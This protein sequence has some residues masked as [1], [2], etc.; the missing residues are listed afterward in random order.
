VSLPGSGEYGAHLVFSPDGQYLFIVAGDRQEFEPAQDLGNTIGKIVRLK[1]DGSI[2]ADNPFVGVAG[3]LP[4][5]WT[6]GHRN[7]YGLAFNAA[8][9]LWQ[10]EMG[11]RGGDEFN[12][13]EPGNNYGWPRVSN[14]SHYDGGDIPDHS[15]GDGF[16]APVIS[17]NPV[18]APSDM[19]IYSGYLF[20]AWRGDAILG[21]LQY[22]GLI[23]V[24]FDGTSASE[25][26]RILLNARIRAVAQG[27]DDS[28]WVL[29]DKPTGRLLKLVPAN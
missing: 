12:L 13:I 8:G 15:P 25:V 5:I 28:I 9:R 11:P 4:E 21:G 6:L 7:P 24:R 20:S 18:I 10:H 14:G 16:T 29:E 3:A 22:K 2:P 26:Q 27:P 17:W 1:A 19:I 23:R